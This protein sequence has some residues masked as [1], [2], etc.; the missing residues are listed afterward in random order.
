MEEITYEG[1]SL[2]IGSRRKGFR[3]ED[4]IRQKNPELYNK[5]QDQILDHKIMDEANKDFSDIC[6]KG[7]KSH[8]DKCYCIGEDHPRELSLLLD[9]EQEEDEYV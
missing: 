4:F 8:E 9:K 1:M 3:V 7:I 6:K 5:T 2:S